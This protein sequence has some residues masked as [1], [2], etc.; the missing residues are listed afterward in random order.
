[1]ETASSP[2]KRKKSFGI[3]VNKLKTVL[4]KGS[5]LGES[6]EILQT[7]DGQQSIA[8]TLLQYVPPKAWLVFAA[9]QNHRPNMQADSSPR[10]PE[11][12]S[13]APHSMQTPPEPPEVIEADTIDYHNR[14]QVLMLRHNL[15]V[16]P[17][18]WPAR[19]NPPQERVSKSIRMRVRYICHRCQTSFGHDKE[20]NTCRHRRCARC[21]RYPPR[22]SRQSPEVQALISA[23]LPFV[24]ETVSRLSETIAA[25]HTCTCHECQTTIEIEV[26]GCPNCQHII[27]E[28]C[29]KGARLQ[30]LDAQPMD[31]TLPA[32]EEERITHPEE[33]KLPPDSSSSTEDQYSRSSR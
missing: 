2:A 4:R 24:E 5:T 27:C 12:V 30:T 29:H 8:P 15:N 1:M 9:D 26:E 18:K 19:M 33:Q 31:I 21:D 11:V 6:E 28:Q 32:G 23:P 17:P 14:T 20:C 7:T 16:G 10:K 13:A 22:K 3:L 25:D